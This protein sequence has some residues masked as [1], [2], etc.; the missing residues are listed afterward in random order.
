MLCLIEPDFTNMTSSLHLVP[1]ASPGKDKKVPSKRSVTLGL[2]PFLILPFESHGFFYHHLPFS[3]GSFLHHLWRSQKHAF[4]K[5]LRRIWSFPHSSAWWKAIF[6]RYIVTCRHQS[7]WNVLWPP[8]QRYP[9]NAIT[10]STEIIFSTIWGTSPSSDPNSPTSFNIRRTVYS[11]DN[12]AGNGDSYEDPFDRLISSPANSLLPGPPN[13]GGSRHT[14]PFP[15]FRNN[16]PVVVRPNSEIPIDNSP[17]GNNEN[18]AEWK[19]LQYSL[20]L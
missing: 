6:W 1:I 17:G 19:L 2:A 18:P 14:L 13:N 16:Q 20:F 5:K 9:W 10:G 15:E 7:K 8:S 3:G 4:G 11:P 12:G